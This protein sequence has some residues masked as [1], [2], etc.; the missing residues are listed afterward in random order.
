MSFTLPDLPYP[1]DALEPHLDAPTMRIHHDLHHATYVAKLNEAVSQLPVEPSSLVDV[2]QRLDQAP[3]ELRTALRNHGGGHLNHCMLWKSLSADSGI[4]SGPLHEAMH[5]SFG[6]TQQMCDK[7]TAAAAGVFGSG[8]AW[9]A[10]DEAGD[11]QIVT[12][13]N[14]DNPVSQGLLPILGIDVWEHAYYLAYQNR[15][16]AY[17]EAIMHVIDWGHVS[18]RYERLLEVGASALDDELV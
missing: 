10:S 1:P 9:I 6:G 15:R 2:L 8:W 5:G 17:L 14:Q 12:S 3:A 4:M 13:A 18:D 11:L 16:P 7:L